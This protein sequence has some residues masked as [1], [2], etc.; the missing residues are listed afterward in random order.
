MVYY[1]T[2]RLG[3][4]GTPIRSTRQKI[5]DINT[6]LMSI[7]NSSREG[8]VNNNDI[9]RTGNKDL[10]EKIVKAFTQSIKMIFVDHA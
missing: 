5:T 2:T 8:N 3:N 4:R 10:Q 6:R 1:I 7:A 9:S